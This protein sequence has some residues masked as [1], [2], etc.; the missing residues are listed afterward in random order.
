[1]HAL[2]QQ[3]GAH[4]NESDVPL[5]ASVA[6]MKATAAE[7]TKTLITLQKIATRIAEIKKASEQPHAAA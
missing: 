6:N 4:Q 2:G 1:M 3:H 7:M 5:E